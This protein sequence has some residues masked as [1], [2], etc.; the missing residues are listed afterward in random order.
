MQFSGERQE[1]NVLQWFRM[2]QFGKG[3]SSRLFFNEQPQINWLRQGAHS[4]DL[5]SELYS[6]NNA[7]QTPNIVFGIDTTTAEGREKFK[8]EWEQLHQLAPE[9][10]KKEDFL[11]PHE[12]GAQI[13]N[14]PHYQRVWQ[15]YREHSLKAQIEAAV[16][17][18]SVSST[19]AEAA[20]KFLG[21]KS[22]L[23]VTSYV[24]AKKGLRPDLAKSEEFHSTDRVMTAIGMNEAELTVTTAE[25]FEDQFWN[26]FDGTYNLTD[27][28]L[29]EEIPYF[30]TDTSNRTKVE[31]IMEGRDQD[32]LEETQ[33]LA[34]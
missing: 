32:A 4:E 25:G 6:F 7:N 22:N 2:E 24:L 9:I 26:N 1:A 8:A 30:I 16:E 19:D 18:G 15:L 29:K 3:L 14:E 10:I 12:M 20:Q 33:Q 23:S 34:A 28:S 27:A 13:S 31:A 11:Y 5:D 17:I 21:S